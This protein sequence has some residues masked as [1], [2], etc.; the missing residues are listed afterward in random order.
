MPAPTLKRRTKAPKLLVGPT[1]S[2]FDLVPHARKHR[3]APTG[4]VSDSYPEY[5]QDAQ[6]TT[7]GGLPVWEFVVDCV[8]PADNA[9]ETALGALIGTDVDFEYQNDSAIDPPTAASRKA[10]GTGVLEPFEFANDSGPNTKHECTIKVTVS[11][12]PLF[13][14]AL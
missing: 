2:L 13:D 1:G 10:S 5:D 14:P 9:I 7:P 3:L 11:G 12:L 4:S 6:T 8:H